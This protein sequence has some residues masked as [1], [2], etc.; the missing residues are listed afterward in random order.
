MDKLSLPQIRYEELLKATSNWE[1]R[2]ILG[3]GG[4]GTVFKGIW[5]H[6]A[7]AIKRM[8]QVCVNINLHMI[9][10]DYYVVITKIYTACKSSIRGK[11]NEA[12]SG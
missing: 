9:V 1:R 2:H 5:K 4:F 12:I 7:V 10:P 11:S 3:K 6:T 8:E